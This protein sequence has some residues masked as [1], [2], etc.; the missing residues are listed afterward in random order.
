MG[1]TL[2]IKQN[3]NIFDMFAQYHKAKEFQDNL[4]ALDNPRTKQIDL[5]Q[6]IGK[7][8]ESFW[9]SRERY[10]VI[11]GSRASK[12]SKVTAL[13]YITNMMEFSEANLVVIRKHLNTHR[14]STRND[15]IWAINRLG[16]KDD[17]Y[18]SKSDNGDLTITRI[19]TGH[20]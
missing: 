4:P 13:F 12:K 6:I 10:R 8:Y 1:V 17:W 2:A 3:N 18:Y 19:S 9:Y 20:S 14:T 11:K 15:L 5:N 16:V 7:E